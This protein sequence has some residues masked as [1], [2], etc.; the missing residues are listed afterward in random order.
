VV[1]ET[2]GFPSPAALTGLSGFLFEMMDVINLEEKVPHCCWPQVKV[3]RGS[4]LHTWRDILGRRLTLGAI[5]LSDV[6]SGYNLQQCLARA[7][8]ARKNDAATGS[9]CTRLLGEH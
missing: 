4:G 3:R 1:L 8:L 7:Q 9:F 6:S 5:A 2:R